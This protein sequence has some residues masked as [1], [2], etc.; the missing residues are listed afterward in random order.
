M[1]K[2]VYLLLSII[3]A[4]GISSCVDDTIGTSLSNNDLHI[5]SDSTFT[6]SGVSERNEVILTRT[7]TQLLGAINVKNFGELKSDFV[8]QF[9][10]STS[11]DTT[12]LTVDMIE[13]INLIMRSP[14]GAYTGD[15]IMPMRVN[16][17]QLEK[18][19]ST[20]INSNFSPEGY[21][22]DNSLIGSTAYTATFSSSPSFTHSTMEKGTYR[23]I[24]TPL[25]KELAV[26]IF[27]E[28]KKDPNSFNSP[29][30]FNELFPGI[31]V[32]NSYGSGRITKIDKTFLLVNYKRHSKTE[33][34]NDT[35][36]RDSSSY[37]T[38]APE[39]ITN[40][41]ITM[42]VDEN[43]VNK[44]NQGEVI[45]QAPLGYNAR[46]K[47]P[48]DE[49]VRKYNSDKDQLKVINALSFT[50][51]AE[52]IKN[53]YDIY[54]PQYILLV[55]T[56]EKDKFFAN[57]KIPDNITSFYAEFN[58]TTKT[59]EFSDM[60]QFVLNLIDATD[61]ELADAAD[62]TI[63]PIDVT[64]EANYDY[65]GQANYITT[66]ITPA[67][68]GPMIG[69]LKLDDVKIKFTYSKKTNN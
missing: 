53:D 37:A 42:K 64:K 66:G 65:L 34:G 2:A 20:P 40:N 35:I 30:K 62:M 61:D 44:V 47:F 38:A 48:I 12:N 58:V 23:N 55:K 33:A 19:L 49:I 11:I 25:P 50:L 57:N 39:V 8:C 9:L 41:N 52:V 63:I 26:K 46:I 1:K 6:V 69:K 51:P 16:V 27:N 4:G 43:I 36:V 5:V 3:I 7:M 29:N 59:Y 14:I 56:S 32:A 24:V 60:R 22:S 15:S 28:F 18:Q 21:Y 13:S 54:I 17:Y 31:Y 45:I 68:S 67:V 10:P